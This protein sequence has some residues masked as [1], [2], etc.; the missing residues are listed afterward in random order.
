MVNLLGGDSQKQHKSF[1]EDF[2][3]AKSKFFSYGSTGTTADFKSN[4]GVESRSEAGT[5]VLSF[6]LDPEEQAGPGKGPEII[7]KK[8][9]HFGTYAARLKVPDV[10]QQQPNV[11]AVA[12]YFTYHENEQEG[13]SE[14]DFEWLLADPRIIYVGTWTGQAGRLQRIGRIIN[15]AEGEILETISK[16]NYDGEPTALTGLQNMPEVVSA[17]SDYDASSGF[18]TYGFDWNPERIRWWMLHP[19]TGDTLV[20]WDYQGSQLG[21]PQHAS[22]Y[23]MNF[24][25]TQDWAVE[26]N[27]HSLEKPKFRYEL[28]VD[29][30]EYRTLDKP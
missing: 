8:F 20:L 27:P 28:E 25:H 12:G 29:W 5:K 21:I 15:L 4:L 10:R 1:R 17:I 22:K 9:T 26:G 13:L 11:G 24:W 6:K 3:K 16:V 18:Y 2:S 30:M 19:S 7:S 14:I 23:R